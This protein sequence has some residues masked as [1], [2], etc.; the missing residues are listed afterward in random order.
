MTFGHQNETMLRLRDA[1][2]LAEAEVER[3]RRYARELCVIVVRG[4]DLG[5]FPARIPDLFVQLDRERVLIVAPETDMRRAEILA[6]R[7]CATTGARTEGMAS[8]PED[9]TTF[10][11][12]MRSAMSERQAGVIDGV[13]P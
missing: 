13:A 3:A 8:F 9:G 2:P 11:A 7:I 5:R 1:V 10:P 12:L 4:G 6:S